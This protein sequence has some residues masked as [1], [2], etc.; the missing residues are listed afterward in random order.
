M[1]DEPLSH[2]QQERTE[3]REAEPEAEDELTERGQIH[4]FSS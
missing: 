1:R 4:G 3:Q 2:E